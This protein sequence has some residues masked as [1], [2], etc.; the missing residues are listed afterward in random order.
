MDLT[1]LWPG[2]RVAWLKCLLFPVCLLPLLLF[3]I[4]LFFGFVAE[5]VEEIRAFSGQ[6]TLKFLLITLGVSPLRKLPGMRQAIRFRR[7]LGLFSF[8]YACIH[9]LTW[10]ILDQNLQFDLIAG[11]IVEKPYVIVGFSSFVI[12]S[13]LAATS[14][15]RI[16]RRLGKF[17]TKLHRL[18]YFAAIL[19]V[20]HFL[21]LVKSDI[22]E[23]VVYSLIA[24]VL[25][26]FR[27]PWKRI[28]TVGYHVEKTGESR[29]FNR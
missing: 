9:F 2:N 17:W 14:P 22:S 21:W 4:E 29:S 26:L 28:F 23:P 11:N 1:S 13:A 15:K 19:S 18:I 20:L 3:F 12:L 27:I 25:L 24:T 8:F 7:M 10:I 6:W 16:M 5:P